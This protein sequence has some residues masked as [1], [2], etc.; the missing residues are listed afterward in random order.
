[1]FRYN[2]EFIITKEGTTVEADCPVIISASRVCDIPAFCGDWLLKQFENGYTIW[3]N[4]FNRK[5]HYISF[6]KTR[7]IVFWTKNPLPFIKKLP[8]IE[9]YFKNYYFHFTLNDYT[10]EKLEQGLPKLNERIETFKILSDTIGKN[11]IIWRF[12]PLILTC[13]TDIDSLIGKIE[14][15]GNSLYK[16]TDKLVLSFADIDEY[17]RVKNRFYKSKIDYKNFTEE[18]IFNIAEKLKNLNNTWNINMAA[19]AENIDLTEFD[20][21]PNKCIDDELIKSVFQNDK[22]LVNYAE[23]AKKDKGQRKYCNCIKSKDIG[24]YRSCAYNCAYCYAK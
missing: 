14:F 19:C 11:K 8:E 18:E 10:E 12:D 21:Y 15:I 24:I 16:Y 7:L 20:I 22:E 5:K 1:M 23:N 3:I 6:S 17:K 9:K 13:N 2:K 4:P